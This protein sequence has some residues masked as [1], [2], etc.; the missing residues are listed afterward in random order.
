MKFPTKS[1]L[2][3]TTALG[4]LFAFTTPD[5]AH[6]GNRAA[7][8]DTAQHPW[9]HLVSGD[10]EDDDE[11][12]DDQ[13]G[14][15][16]EDADEDCEM[17]GDDEDENDDDCIPTQPLPPIGTVAPPANGLFGN[18]TPPKVQVN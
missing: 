2:A 15:D 4:A 13:E 11:E 12:D 3:A 6:A 18:G 10:D 7:P 8:T 1:L 16:E 9:V 14:D 5:G 17:D